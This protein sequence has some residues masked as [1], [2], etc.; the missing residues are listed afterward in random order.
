MPEYRPSV[1]EYRQTLKQREEHIRES[2]VKAMEARI[3]RR[4]LQDCYN[5]EGVNN[6]EVCYDLA[7]KYLAMIRDNKVKGYKVIDQE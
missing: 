2:W 1:D 4:E 5:T 7:Q 6:I 3:V